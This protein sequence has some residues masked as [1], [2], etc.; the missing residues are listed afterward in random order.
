[1]TLQLR[2]AAFICGNLAA[3]ALLAWAVALPAAG[4]LADQRERIEAQAK[5]LA[6]LRAEA[7]TAPPAGEVPRAA[8]GG[9]PVGD[10]LAGSGEGA[11]SANLQAR[12]KL[13]AE[14]AGASLRSVRAL[15]PRQSGKIAHAGARLEISGEL[16][17]VQ[18]SLYQVE[19][20]LPPL[21]ITACIVRLSAG[22]GRG[23]DEPTVEAQFD[24]YGAVRGKSGDE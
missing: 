13:T 17:S 19:G 4:A 2:S 15:P 24:V 7:R 10:F 9:E 14:G 5:V 12:L 22:G 20:T 21:T 16:R 11:V 6:R 3:L 18:A 1:M 8:A 23:G